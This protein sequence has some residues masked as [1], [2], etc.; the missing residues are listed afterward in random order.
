MR[1]RRMSAHHTLAWQIFI[2]VAVLV[3]LAMGI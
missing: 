3:D 1:T 2:C